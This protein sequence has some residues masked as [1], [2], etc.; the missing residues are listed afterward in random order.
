MAFTGDTN[1]HDTK[2][3]MISINDSIFD[4]M[5][6]NGIRWRVYHDGLSFFALYPKLWKHVLGKNFRDYEFLY[7][8]MLQEPAKTAPQ[9]IIVEPSYQDAPHIGSDRPNDNHAPLAIGWGEEFLRR[10]YQ[11]VIANTAKW[12]NTVMINYYDEH[13]GFY[14]HVPPPLIPYSVT[15]KS[16]FNFESLGP[17]IPGVIV[18]PLVKPGSVCHSIFDHTS[19]LQFLAEKFT[20]GKP[21]S[22]SVQKRGNLGI[23]SISQALNNDLTWNP[24]PPP[25][26]A[27]NVRTALGR[28]IATAPVNDLEASFEMAANELL[29]KERAAVVK[30]YPEL[31]LWKDA[32]AAARK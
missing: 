27:L 2:L 31:L 21:Y 20:P 26:Q 30:K 25:S 13:G 12:Q 4:W 3:R 22:T 23:A 28:T 29:Q 8:D 15:G 18:S 14:D 16:P 1:I 6:R 9:V 19:V 32:V 5:D 24:P 7:R 17:R 10:T 11:A